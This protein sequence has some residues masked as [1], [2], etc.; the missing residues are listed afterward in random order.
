MK[1]SLNWQ[2]QGQWLAALLVFPVVWL[3]TLY[4]VFSYLGLE[5]LRI[6]MLYR[7]ILLIAGILVA[8]THRG[9][10]AWLL[11]ILLLWWSLTLVMLTYPYGDVTFVTELTL[12]TRW[13][14]PFSVLLVTL[15]LLEKFGDQS[16]LLIRGI[17]YYGWVFGC[18][19]LFSFVTGLGIQSYGDIAFGIKSFY[20]GGNDIG[21]TALMS[22]SMLFV[23]LY[24]RVSLWGLIK[25]TLCLIGLMLLGTKAG[26]L[27][28]IAL[29]MAFAGIL[30][31]FKPAHSV[32]QLS[33][34]TFSALVIAAAVGIAGYYV[35]QN[36]DEFEYQV[37]Q[38]NQLL[39]GE[40]PRERLIQS[41]AD[42]L[43][44]YPDRG[45]W[46]GAGSEF[47]QGAGREYYL[48][49]NNN[50]GYS[51]FKSIEQEWMDLRGG[52][53]VPFAALIFL[54]H[55]FFIVAA[56]WLW[57]RRPTV[58]H[59][60]IVAALLIYFVHGYFA[61]HAFV[62]GQ[63]SGVAGV[64]YGLI[65]YRIQREFMNPQPKTINES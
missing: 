33:A 43:E 50:S 39:E 34:K 65:V 9:P 16:A 29:T 6:S 59:F 45:Q 2:Q 42:H 35:Q 58:E 30:L 4:G 49:H 32:L 38:V 8:F 7:T 41:G 62:S 51:T 24:Q 3:D 14:Y 37:T 64:L 21:L 47:Y 53:G 26:A 61:G 28:G 48:T 12:A 31:I 15:A 52:F 56:I 22:L 1:L 54:T 25:I 55:I 27:G 60:G 40:S 63:P 11:K 44:D 13:L 46:F 20:V 18:F 19:M 23:L 36:I 17:A 5:A 10:F 57:F